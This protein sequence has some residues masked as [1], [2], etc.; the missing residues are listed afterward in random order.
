MCVKANT[1]LDSLKNSV[2]TLQLQQ[3]LTVALMIVWQSGSDI[4]IWMCCNDDQLINHRID[5]A[6][7][8]ITLATWAKNP[9]LSV[10]YTHLHLTTCL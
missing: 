6:W 2:C 1:R 7:N 4:G 8:R 3:L 5:L 10:G 9:W